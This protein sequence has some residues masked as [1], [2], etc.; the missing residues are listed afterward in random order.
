MDDEF[1]KTNN[2]RKQSLSK[3][4]LTC[5]GDNNNSNKMNDVNNN[6]GVENEVKKIK[7]KGKS[8]RS[9]VYSLVKLI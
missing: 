2:K 1:K 9:K 6:D 7:S 8:S 4:V 5:E 3:S